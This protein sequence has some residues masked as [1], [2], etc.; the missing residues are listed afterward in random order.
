MPMPCHAYAHARNDR[1]HCQL[2]AV[3]ETTDRAIDNAWIKS[4]S[5]SHHFTNAYAMQSRGNCIT[6]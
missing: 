5:Q 3:V 2:E 4:F 6:Y 1:I